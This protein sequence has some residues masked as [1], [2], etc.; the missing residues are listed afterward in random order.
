MLDSK[1]DAE[2]AGVMVG[3]RQV[4]TTLALTLSFV[5]EKADEQ[6]LPA[7]QKLDTCPLASLECV[8]YLGLHRLGM[9]TSGR[10]SQVA[11]SAH[12]LH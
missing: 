12:C 8:G 10:V 11:W 9:S 7:G 5:V 4:R 2:G 1:G 6:I 3:C